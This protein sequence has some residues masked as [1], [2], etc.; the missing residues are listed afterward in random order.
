MSVIV[1]IAVIILEIRG[2]RI[3]ISDRKWRIFAYYTQISNIITLISSVVFIAAI[4]TGTIAA[5]TMAAGSAAGAVAGIPVTLRYL[6][7]CMLTM[8]FLITLFVLVPMGAGFRR[9]MLSGN[10][11]YHHTLCPVLSVTSYI[12][13]EGHSDLWILPTILTF[14]YGM[15]MLYMNAKGK[16]DGPYPFFRVQS[17]SKA[18]TVLWMAVLTGVIAAISIGI[19]MA[20]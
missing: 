12:L 13:W 9:M 18:A 17:Q 4:A 7:S 16:F 6:S 1:N 19:S 8:T 14:V 20:S 5:G 10:G 11:L 3:S 15:I 2:L